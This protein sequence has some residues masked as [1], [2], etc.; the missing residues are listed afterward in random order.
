M[1][2]RKCLEPRIK[3]T[4]EDIMKILY[5]NFTKWAWRLSPQGVKWPWPEVNHPPTSTAKVQNEW[6]YSPTCF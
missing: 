2:S 4:T 6:N 1:C 3:W 5:T